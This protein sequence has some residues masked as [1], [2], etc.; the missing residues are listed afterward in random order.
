MLVNLNGNSNTSN[1]LGAYSFVN[2]IKGGLV[3]EPNTQI[4]LVNA[5]VERQSDLIIST[6][7]GT[8]QLGLDDPSDPLLHDIHIP[9]GTYDGDSLADAITDGLNNNFG[10]HGYIFYCT[11]DESQNKFN[12]RWHEGKVK[13]NYGRL[14]FSR[15]SDANVMSNKYDANGTKLQI[16]NSG[17]GLGGDWYSGTS[18]SQVP[19]YTSFDDPDS[20]D[21]GIIYDMSLKLPNGDTQAGACFGIIHE[22]GFIDP[23]NHY[24]GAVGV[25]LESL[26]GTLQI[27]ESQIGD[28]KTDYIYGNTWS[29]GT[30]NWDFAIYTGTGHPDA[31]DYMLTSSGGTTHYMKQNDVQTVLYS[32]Q[33]DGHI[34]HV[35][36]LSDDLKTLTIATIAGVPFK[37]FT[38]TTGA[39]INKGVSTIVYN[40]NEPKIEFST[41][42]NGEGGSVRMNFGKSGYVRYWYKAHAT[43]NAWSEIYLDDSNRLQTPA[44]FGSGANYFYGAI[45][46]PQTYSANLNEINTISAITSL[47]LNNNSVDFNG[48]VKAHDDP[49]FTPVSP[50][51]SQNKVVLGSTAGS[52]IIKEA[53]AEA[54]GNIILKNEFGKFSFIVDDVSQLCEWR[55]GLMT[56]TK[57][58]ALNATGS[59]LNIDLIDM[60][61]ICQ[62]NSG[63]YQVR[64]KNNATDKGTWTDFATMGDKPKITIVKDSGKYCQMYYSTLANDYNDINY[65]ESTKFTVATNRNYCPVIVSVSNS[66]DPNNL[67]APPSFSNIQVSLEN[68]HPN[69]ALV[70]FN[71]NSMNNILGF[72]TKTLATDDGDIGFTSN[73]KVNSSSIIDNPSIHL[74]LKNLPLLSLNGKTSL[75]EKSLAVIPRYLSKN[76]NTGLE[77]TQYYEPNNLLYKNLYNGERIALNSFDVMLTNNDGSLA[78]DITG[79]DCTLDV[80]PNPY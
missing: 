55:V 41:G 16:N 26:S 6:S 47:S 45:K 53:T 19:D 39:K 64:G 21:D 69:T 74:Q 61:I 28:I 71:A 38:S 48:S 23:D 32:E 30:N 29:D 20:Y 25:K 72:S 76:E 51:A 36:T 37:T 68:T 75:T 11:Y 4:A 65:I 80:I 73:R 17:G 60:A 18:S 9:A 70:H 8:I 24:Y 40:I 62:D 54:M 63:T 10:Q 78:T 7:N 14:T 58:T 52:S 56:D 59:D 42:A 79:F 13:G 27:F 1:S 15:I 5:I 50:L 34:T 2:H 31:Y 33:D 12:I 44:L 43:D 66:T 46:F 67:N 22:N 3:L 77:I 57:V 49:V 35:G